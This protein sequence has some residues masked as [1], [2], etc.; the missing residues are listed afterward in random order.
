MNHPGEFKMGEWKNKTGE[1]GWMGLNEWIIQDDQSRLPLI[2]YALHDKIEI[3]VLF[4][5]YK[6]PVWQNLLFLLI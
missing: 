2:F 3:A 4:S 1:S 5:I 6:P